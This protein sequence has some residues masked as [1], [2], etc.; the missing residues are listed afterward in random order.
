MLEDGRWVPTFPNAKY[1]FSKPEYEA[2]AA[3]NSIVFRESVAPIMEAGQAE[4]VDMDFALDDHIWLSPTP[5]HTA[6][7]VAINM[8]SNG[9]QGAMSGDLVHSPLQCVHPD[10]CAT[11]DLDMALAHQTRQS[12]F[13]LHADQDTTIMTAHF[14]LPSVGRIVSRGDGFWFEYSS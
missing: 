11:V 6:G 7:H 10:L 8:Q 9:A 2:A 5:G 3:G 12:F 1:V 14:P 13:E 4:L